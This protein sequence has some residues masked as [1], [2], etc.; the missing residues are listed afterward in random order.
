MKISLARTLT[1]TSLLLFSYP[2]FGITLEESGWTK[3]VDDF[4]GT[5]SYTF[6]PN[7]QTYDCGDSFATMHLGLVQGEPKKTPLILA[8]YF[9][10]SEEIRRSG[11][12][13]WKTASGTDSIGF[14]CIPDYNDG[15]YLNQCV[16]SGITRTTSKSLSN[17][18]YIRISSP[19]TKLSNIDVKSDDADNNCSNMLI[20][21]K[22]I[23]SDYYQAL[24]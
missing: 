14:T 2:S 5:V 23:T 12:L 4:E 15:S 21:I 3:K 9:V 8:I 20:S 7:L 11:D 19:N 10:S 17:T 22:R 24:D 18:S 13:K 6:N 1:L 16:T